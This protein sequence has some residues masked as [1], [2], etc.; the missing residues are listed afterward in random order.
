VIET[1]LRP[2]PP[3][4]ERR[5][6]AG[7]TECD[8]SGAEAVRT[9][10]REHE[11]ALLACA[12]RFTG[13]RMEAQDAVQEVFLRAWQHLPALL[14]DDRP[15][16]PWLRTV[17]RHVLT[18]RARAARVRPVT[19]SAVIPEGEV[20]GGFDALLD[21]S[22]LREAIERL[23]PDHRHVVVE[24]YYH[25]APADRLAAALGVPVGTIRSRLHYALLALR[26]QLSSPPSAPA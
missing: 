9:L 24:T 26:R 14:L 16:R 3:P 20:D 11:A 5:H 21:R 15:L 22:W 25:D 18:D 8:E 13:D 4:G 17:L 19:P 7:T 2:A 12:S 1:P 10:Y 23:S 6:P